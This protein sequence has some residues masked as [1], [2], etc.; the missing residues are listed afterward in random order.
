M[1]TGDPDAAAALAA[2]RTFG[3]IP[4][5]MTFD[6]IKASTSSAVSRSTFA[7]S[8]STPGTSVRNTSADAPSSPA[9]PAAASSAFTFS[10]VPTSS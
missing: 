7:P 10:G 5:V 6:S 2:A 8:R 1:Y 4:P 9:T 3:I